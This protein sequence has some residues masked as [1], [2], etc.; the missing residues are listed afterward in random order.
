MF[1]AFE[2]NMEGEELISTS[3][4]PMEFMALTFGGR[5]FQRRAPL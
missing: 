4:I 1:A 3:N 5:I 2:S